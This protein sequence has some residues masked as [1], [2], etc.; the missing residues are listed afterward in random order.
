MGTVDGGRSY[1]FTY[2]DGKVQIFQYPGATYTTFNG[3]NNNGIIEIPD[4]RLRGLSRK[5]AI[6]AFR[7]ALGPLYAALA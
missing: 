2:T 3:I 1:G 4:M 7:C 5:V 6:P